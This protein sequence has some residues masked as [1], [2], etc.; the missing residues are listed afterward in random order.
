MA[1][2]DIDRELFLWLIR[3]EEQELNPTEKKQFALYLKKNPELE[4]H[5][6]KLKAL[7]QEIGLVNLKDP[8]R[9]C[10]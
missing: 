7:W 5:V 8:H 6:T 9:V 2:K 1:K 10:S 4:F 3:L